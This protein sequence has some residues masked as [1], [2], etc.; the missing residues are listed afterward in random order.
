MSAPGSWRDCLLF[1]GEVNSRFIPRRRLI[2]KTSIR[3]LAVREGSP[4][5][6]QRKWLSLS[7][8]LRR[9]ER[10]GGRGGGM[11]G[12]RRE[13]QP[14]PSRWVGYGF[15]RRLDFPES[16]PG[17]TGVVGPSW[18]VQPKWVHTRCT[19]L[20]LLHDASRPEYTRAVVNF[21][22]KP[23]APPSRPKV[24]KLDTRVIEE[25]ATLPSPPWLC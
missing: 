9:S 6:K 11:G 19:L 12:G 10:R 13:R 22:S 20:N 5:P 23:P 2:G 4:T 8:P 7:G 15:G 14:Y 3:T 24:R 25:F 1:N 18:T 17:G 16:M 21:T